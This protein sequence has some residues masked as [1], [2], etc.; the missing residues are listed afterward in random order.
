MYIGDK[1]MKNNA[2]SLLANVLNAAVK[3]HELRV[4][5][6]VQCLK[7]LRQGINKNIN[8]PTHQD[9]EKYGNIILLM[10]CFSPP[11]DLEN[12][13]EAEIR[14]NEQYSKKFQ[15]KG[16]LRRI[17][18]LNKQPITPNPNQEANIPSYLSSQNLN[19][20]NEPTKTNV[21]YNDL[22]YPYQPSIL[23]SATATTK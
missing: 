5:L 13:I 7:M 16:L 3:N 4:E 15:C 11:K 21:S 22:L 8:R 9:K 14:R 12:I 17:C 20:F 2:N 19:A 10:C 23:S 1:K 18:I 6:Y